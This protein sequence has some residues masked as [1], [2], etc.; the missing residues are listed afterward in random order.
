MKATCTGRPTSTK[1]RYLTRCEEKDK[2][3]RF[4]S[5]E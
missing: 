4:P 3:G 1:P 2:E 5:Y